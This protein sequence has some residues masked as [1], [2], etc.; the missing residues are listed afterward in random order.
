MKKV[1]LVLLLAL[2]A[3]F[4]VSSAAMADAVLDFEVTGV[5]YENGVLTATGTFTNSGD[6]TIETVNKVDIKIFLYNDAGD[7]VQ[8]ADHYFTDLAMHLEPGAAIEYSLA[9]PDVAEYTD[10]TKWSAEEGE[11]EFT[12]LEEAAAAAETAP[13]SLDFAVT[14]VG[15]EDGKLTAVGLFTNTGGKSI[16]TVDSVNIKITLFNAD[17]DSKQVADHVFSNLAVNLKPGEEIE[18]SLEFTDVPEYTDATSW[19]ADEDSW[20]FTYFE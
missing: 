5:A 2:C 17:G 3:L 13:A 16:A 15:Y 6:K 10:A 7:S 9:F 18:Y 19:S 12:Y 20:E 14:S 11:W 8:A 4:A 1:G